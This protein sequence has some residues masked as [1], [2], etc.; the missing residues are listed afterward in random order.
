M[1]NG[2]GAA[3][4]AAAAA[5]GSR[6]AGRGRLGWRRLCCPLISFSVR[7]HIS[8]SFSP[9]ASVFL[10]QRWQV[11]CVGNVLANWEWGVNT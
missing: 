5:G 6:G 9:F 8:A 10:L 2:S 11:T 4:T 1:G 3:L 7:S